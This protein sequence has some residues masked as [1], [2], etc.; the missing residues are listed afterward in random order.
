MLIGCNIFLGPRLRANDIFTLRLALILHVVI[1]TLER[2]F[3][4]NQRNH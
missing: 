3:S 4:T 1:A 2:S